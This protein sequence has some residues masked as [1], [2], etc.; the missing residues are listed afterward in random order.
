MSVL[1]R[2]PWAIFDI[3]L[4]QRVTALIAMLKIGS[5]TVSVVDPHEVVILVGKMHLKYRFYLRFKQF[6]FSDIFNIFFWQIKCLYSKHKN[7]S[8][9]QLWCLEVLF[10]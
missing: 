4:Q 5:I 10:S 7:V 9:S 8:D 3:D 1:G 2:P 6:L